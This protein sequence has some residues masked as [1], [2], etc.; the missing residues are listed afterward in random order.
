MAQHQHSGQG[1]E[2]PSAQASAPQVTVEQ[3][4]QLHASHINELRAEILNQQAVIARMSQQQ[5]SGAIRPPKP[6]TFDGRQCETFIYSLE[7]LFAYHGEQ[8]SERK[9][10]LAVTFLRGSALRWYRCAERQDTNGGLRNWNN[11][12]HEMKL[13]F[14]ASNTETVIRNKLA[15]LKQ[16]GSVNKYNDLYNALIIEIVGMDATTKRDMYIRGLKSTIQ[17]HVALKDPK[18]LEEAQRLA[19]DI[20][21]ILSE[22][23]FSQA[24]RDGNGNIN[25]NN[26]KNGNKKNSNRYN[27]RFNNRYNQSSAQSVPMDLSQAQN[28][29]NQDEYDDE[30]EA[31]V[32]SAQSNYKGNRKMST[33][34]QRQLMRE[35][36]C[37]GCGET[38]HL[39]KDCPQRK[40][41]ND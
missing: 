39:V 14:L 16:L 3:V 26:M 13:F 34:Q 38:G 17:L 8:D 29:Y 40:P 11:F 9:V 37:F 12:T 2:A 30:D 6:D 23:G 41:K 27:N 18:S 21:G 7:K 33:E 1:N 28:E 20:D 25:N 4:V 31:T 15:N 10:A 35:G 36:R 32:S 19:L 24:K 22:T 5:S